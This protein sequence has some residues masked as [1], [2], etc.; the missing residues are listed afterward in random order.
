MQSTQPK[1][2]G[3]TR[4]EGCYCVLDGIVDIVT[5]LKRMSPKW[6][7]PAPASTINDWAGGRLP[8]GRERS[9]IRKEK[10][11][12][13]KGVVVVVTVVQDGALARRC[14]VSWSP[15]ALYGG[16]SG[17]AMPALQNEEGR[18]LCALAKRQLGESILTNRIRD[19]VLCYLF[20]WYN[21]HTILLAFITC[22][23]QDC[24]GPDRRCWKAFDG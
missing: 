11:A 23:K 8:S 20:C 2:Q 16:S 10:K 1:N 19:R 9:R 4:G 18:R 12:V 15:Q 5:G 7:E 24:T 14:Q 21:N 3:R 13:K 22:S 17:E 6:V